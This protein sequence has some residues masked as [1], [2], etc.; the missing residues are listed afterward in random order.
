MA[1]ATELCVDKVRKADLPVFCID[2]CIWLDFFRGRRRAE[3]IKD[4][5]KEL[6]SGIGCN[7]SIVY[8]EQ[9]VKEYSRH[10]SNVREEFRRIFLDMRKTYSE[11]LDD[12]RKYISPTLVEIKSDFNDLILNE[13]IMP[14]ERVMKKG[15]EY[16]LTDDIYVK[17]AKRSCS[18]IAPSINKDDSTADSVILESFYDFAKR[19]RDAGFTKDIVFI[20]ANIKD[21]GAPGGNGAVHQ[22]I[23]TDMKKLN[24]ICSF[25]LKAVL[26]KYS[27]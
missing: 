12:L 8:P 22:D 16:E 21:F 1:I 20:T 14:I 18:R 17:G 7:Y 9:V 27:H 6:D 13:Y 25:D 2:T 4:L 15:I 11:Y 3:E 24:A 5:I 19:L 23:D 26:G 10:K